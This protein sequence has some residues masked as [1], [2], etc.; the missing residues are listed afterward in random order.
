MHAYQECDWET[1]VLDKNAIDIGDKITIDPLSGAKKT[2]VLKRTGLDFV[3]DN[4]RASDARVIKKIPTFKGE[5]IFLRIEQVN[6]KNYLG[7]Q[8][9]RY[10]IQT[11]DNRPFWH[12]GNLVYKA[13]LT[14]FDEVEIGYNKIRFHK[15]HNEESCPKFLQENMKI[16]KSDLPLLIEGN[17]GTGKSTLAKKIHEMSNA[18]GEFIHIN[19]SAYS[20]TLL[21]SELFGHIRGAFTGAVVD[22]KGAIVRAHRGTLFLDEIDSTSIAIQTKLLLFLDNLKVTPVGSHLGQTVNCRLIFAS[23]SCL[24]KKVQ[25]GQMRLDFY[26]RISRGQKFSLKTLNDDPKSIEKFCH[27]FAIKND[28]AIAPELIEFFKQVKWTGNYRQ[29]AGYLERKKVLA[30]G[31]KLLLDVEDKKLLDTNFVQADESENIATLNEV[32]ESYCIQV[33]YQSKEQISITA[34]KLGVSVKLVRAILQK[35]GIR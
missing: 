12:N 15:A 30:Q 34:E 35:R 32:K 13:F 3:S 29:L 5:R 18:E 11:M 31:R 23:G 27:E 21:E 22:K 20:E 33:Y 8:T 17:T 25:S 14:D 7:N 28:L 16:I 19:L 4:I 24:K 2:F 6:H 10:V 9:L 26:H 1:R